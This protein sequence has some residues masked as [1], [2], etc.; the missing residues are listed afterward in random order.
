MLLQRDPQ[1]YKVATK[2]I[3]IKMFTEVNTSIPSFFPCLPY[4]LLKGK[5]APLL[6]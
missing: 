5:F 2:Q 6:N 3:K 4:Y 1:D